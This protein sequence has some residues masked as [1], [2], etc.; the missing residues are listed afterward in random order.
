MKA[1][2]IYS[3]LGS[4]I[5][6]ADYIYGFYAMGNPDFHYDNTDP[7]T[8]IST[9]PLKNDQILRP[10]VLFITFSSIILILYYL[11]KRQNQNK[12]SKIIFSA[13]P[14]LITIFCYGFLCKIL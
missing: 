3:I 11:F 14:I 5:I 9:Y 10:I 4:I 6:L 2:K 12:V 1:L 7:I 13:L 8:G